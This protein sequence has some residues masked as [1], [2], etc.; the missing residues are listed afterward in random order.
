MSMIRQIH[1]DTYFDLNIDKGR[2]DQ[3]SCFIIFVII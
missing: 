2:T 1:V 3:S